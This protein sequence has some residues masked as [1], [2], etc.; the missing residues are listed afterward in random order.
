MAPDESGNNSLFD[1]G[2]CRR[3]RW[4][5]GRACMKV[6]FENV[7]RGRQTWTADL[8]SLSWRSLER[9]VRR[10]KALASRGVEFEFNADGTAGIILVGGFRPVGTFRAVGGVNLTIEVPV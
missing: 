1:R 6:T 4:F 2:G 7:G 3:L 5:H 10:K 9:E 8:P